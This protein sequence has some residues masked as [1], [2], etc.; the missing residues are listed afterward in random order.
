VPKPL[1]TLTFTFTEE[2]ARWL[3]TA[4]TVLRRVLQGFPS[5]SPTSRPDFCRKGLAV[6]H[7]IAE[8]LPEGHYL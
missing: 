6:L 1:T 2:E 3:A 7:S 5:A 4:V 8:V